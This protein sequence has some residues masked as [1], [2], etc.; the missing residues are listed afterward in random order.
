MSTTVTAIGVTAVVLGI[1]VV[2]FDRVSAV[3]FR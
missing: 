3:F 2:M 1:F